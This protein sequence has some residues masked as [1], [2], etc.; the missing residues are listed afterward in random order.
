MPD[1]G[2]TVDFD[3]HITK[4][5]GRF[6]SSL[7]LASTIALST[8][9]VKSQES[10]TKLESSASSTSAA[11][12]EVKDVMSELQKRAAERDVKMTEMATK[13]IAI[14]EQVD[15]IEKQN[16]QILEAITRISR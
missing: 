16:G 14:K 9:A 15:R 2:N 11:I 13:Q 4:W 1:T 8:C 5:A 3:V 10:I 12:S 7:L 6:I